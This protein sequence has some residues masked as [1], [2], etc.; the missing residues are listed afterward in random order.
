MVF[1]GHMNDR[2]FFS[3]LEISLS[4][5]D[6]MNLDMNRYM[7]YLR[8]L[9]EYANDNGLKEWSKIVK[10]IGFYEY[11][12]GNFDIKKY[13]ETIAPLVQRKIPSEELEELIQND[14]LP[15]DAFLE[16]AKKGYPELSDLINIKLGIN[17]FLKQMSK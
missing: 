2:A 14:M 11:L 10:M 5:Q 4:R 7:H 12:M 13:R 8:L 16:A 1:R 3:Y 17:N 6:V 9:K 15:S